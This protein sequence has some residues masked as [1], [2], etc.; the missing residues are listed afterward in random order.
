MT[1][2]YISFVANINQTTINQLLGLLG[3]QVKA[4]DVTRVHLM[5]SSNGGEVHSGITAY[6]V[7]RSLPVEIHTYN[8]GNVDSIATVVYLAGEHRVAQ[9][10]SSFLF[11]G[12]GMTFQQN[13]RLVERDLEESL[14]SLRKDQDLIG[15]IITDRTHIDADEV[16]Q[17]FTSAACVPPD[18]AVAKGIAHEASELQI[19]QGAA[20][21][22]LVFK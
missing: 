8:F 6:N 3:Q 11:H 14:D 21:F 18:D 19:P 5:I 1:D 10:R 16:H 22:Q 13:A 7:L 15:D 4:A 2:V 12:V 20:F 9:P 17:L